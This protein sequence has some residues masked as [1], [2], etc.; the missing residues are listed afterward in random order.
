[1]AKTLAPRSEISIDHTWNAT[2]VFSS[3]EAWE[4]AVEGVI[5][6]LPNLLAFQGH[7]GDSAARLA[8]WFERVT[9]VVKSL[10][11]VY[12][13]AQMSYAVD[14]TDQLA[15]GQNDRARGLYARVMGT[16]SF[17][18]PEILALGFDTLRRWQAEEP[19]LAIYAHYFDTLEQRQEHVR[20]A[21]VEELLGMVMDPFSTASNT[22]KTLT[23]TDM[24]FEPVQATAGEGEPFTV[25]QGTINSL[26]TNS[27]REVRRM[28]WENYADAHL[29]AK[30]TMANALAA[31]VKQ[32]VFTA[33]ARRYESALEAS[34]KQNYIPLEVFHNLIDTFR[35]NLPTWHRYWDIRRRALG[36]DKLHVYD[37]VAPLTGHPPRV[38]FEQA[39]NWICEGMAPLGADYVNTM[40][41]GALEERWIDIYPNQ[42]KRAGAFSGGAPGTHPFILLSYTDN[43]FS[44]STLAHELGHSMHSYYTWQTQPF[45]YSRYSI[46]VAEV[47]SNFNQALVRDYLFNTNDDPD[48]QI[49]LIEEA[50]A[51][52]HRY[53][54]IMP[55]LAAFEYE[56]HQ[57]VERG[58]AL[59]A[60]TLIDLMADLFAEGY[61]GEVEM[62][63]ERTGITWAQ[64]STHMY[65]NFYVFQYATGISGAH[66]LADGVL[67]GRPGAA[68]RYLDFLKAGSSLYPLDALRGA[69]VDLITPEPVEKTFDV[70]AS[71]VDRLE[72]LVEQRAD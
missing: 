21:E 35:Q 13:Y 7:L 52:F 33:R 71:L 29:A 51:N 6:Q 46:F 60:G 65:L 41:R 59:S 30:N 57:R 11:K 14:T 10:G 24:V 45:V 28:A 55:T 18:E 43:I 5:D 22:H 63:R 2:S 16:I 26:L 61:G 56:I 17:S 25:A 19:R 50:M 72:R 9:P 64:F 8:D 34:L 44:L 12:S 48:F 53:F 20:S 66:A 67:R 23:D 38:S 40:R 3:N 49:A 31:G 32:H 36:S 37:T 42:G 39:M 1:M 69:G 68:E 27:D 54:F 70:L 58:Q 47:A 15:A 62:D 4:A